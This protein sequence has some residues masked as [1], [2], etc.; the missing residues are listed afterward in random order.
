[1]KV[2][3]VINTAW[4]IYN[5][6]QGLIE[7]FH[8]EGWEVVAIAPPDAYV[9]K[10][11]DLGCEYVPIEMENKGANPAKD[12]GLFLRFLSVY[13]KVKPDV[14]LQYTIKPNIYGTLAARSLGIPTI[15]N[16]SGL[17]T[18]FIR[19]NLVSK[20][21]QRL[22][23][24]SFRF[25]SKVFFQNND[26][27]FLFIENELIKHKRIGVL[28]GSGVNLKKYEIVD[29]KAEEKALRF[30]MIARLVF[31]KGVLEY[32]EAAKIIKKQYP[33]VTFVL[34]GFVEDEGGLGLSQKD[35]DQIN[36]DG[37]VRYIGSTDKPKEVIATTDVLV[38]PSY[39]E[40]TPKSLLEGIALGKP[41]LTTDVPG[42]R[43]VVIDGFNGLL[44]EAKNAEDLALKMEEFIQ[45]DLE[46]IV[47]MGL[48]GRELAEE[49]FDE[50]IVI[51]NYIYEIKKIKRF[52]SW[53]K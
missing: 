40:G 7:S 39:R 11:K 2:A 33:N 10:L 30:L 14:I 49:K 5:F 46:G 9:D 16:V 38:L 19:D 36:A 51:D 48:N 44:C 15:N 50:E 22:Y 24:F 3:I 21:A 26:D 41:V 25:P 47:Q 32:L 23:K 8:R 45:M 42:C 34:C 29:C 35:V 43:E 28:P 52:I 53:K 27:K 20:I 17:G 31:D 6:R 18:V 37:F 1:M 12:F 4:N 13:K